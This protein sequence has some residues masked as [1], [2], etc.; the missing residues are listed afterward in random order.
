MQRQPSPGAGWSTA[1]GF[2]NDTVEKWAN[3]DVRALAPRILSMPLSRRAIARAA[4]GAL[5]VLWL[6]MWPS[7][8]SELICVQRELSNA[9]PMPWH[10]PDPRPLVGACFVC[11]ARTGRGRA[12]ERGWASAVLM[13]GNRRVAGAAVVR[14]QAADAYQPGLLALRE[15]LLLETAVRALPVE[16]QVL[17]A[18]ASGRDHP[19]GAGLALHL[20]A[21][22][23]LP[24]IG[25]TDRPLLAAGSGPAR[26][27]WATSPLYIAGEEV[28]RQ[29][30]TRLDAQ[31]VVVHAGWRTDLETAVSVV[32]A[33]VRRA[34]HRS[35]C[36]ALDGRRDVRGQRTKA[37]PPDPP[38]GPAR[39]RS[40]VHHVRAHPRVPEA[41]PA[42]PI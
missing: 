14:G 21:V 36:V 18:N 42:V 20:G 26:H 22:V 30:R 6:E 27:R 25:V 32:R 31:P 3:H 9:R 33:T 19:R 41:D 23:G 2:A 10:S 4:L 40:A 15:G 37:G 7:T 1:V 29:L 35:R 24:S 5:T 34:A 28:A 38:T 16:P 11:F 13:Y 12:G 8:P 17:I 39:R